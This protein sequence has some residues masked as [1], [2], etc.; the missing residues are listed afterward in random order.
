MLTDDYNEV[1]TITMEKRKKDEGKIK[2]W[3]INP[4]SRVFSQDSKKD[5]VNA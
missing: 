5:R 3:V 4:M 2:R 1:R